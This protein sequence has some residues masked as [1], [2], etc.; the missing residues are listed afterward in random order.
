MRA[1]LVA[2]L[3]MALVALAGP[4]AAGPCLRGIPVRARAGESLR[5]TWSDLGPGARE[6]ELELSLAGSRWVR[7]SP[8]LEAR[9]GGFTWRVPAGLA[10]PARLR[11]KFGGEWFEAEG[12]V[13]ASFLIVAESPAPHAPGS[14]ATLGE[15]W[16]LGR[17]GGAIPSQGFARRAV[18]S[19]AVAAIAIAPET[20]RVGRPADAGTPS[21]LV[22]EH[23]SARTLAPSTRE[24]VA[25]RYP[26]RI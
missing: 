24:T 14:E 6:A 3:V 22:S 18:L 7:I 2:S 23:S 20:Q 21:V 12:E 9:E 13:S 19:P 4:A 10:G 26:L 16:N 15:W 11:L 5:I 17:H 1:P 25:R 8:E